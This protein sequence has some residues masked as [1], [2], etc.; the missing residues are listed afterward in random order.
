VEFH[1]NSKFTGVMAMQ[2]LSAFIKD[3]LTT[4]SMNQASLQTRKATDNISEA[5]EDIQF[6]EGGATGVMIP[7]FIVPALLLVTLLLGW[8]PHRLGRCEGFISHSRSQY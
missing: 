8:F 1:F 6:T 2:E 3:E 7:Y 4:T 5:A